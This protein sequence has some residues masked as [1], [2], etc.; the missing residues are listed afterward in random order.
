MKRPRPACD[1]HR[2]VGRYRYRSWGST[3]ET[4]SNQ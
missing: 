4:A 2:G 3:V 1:R